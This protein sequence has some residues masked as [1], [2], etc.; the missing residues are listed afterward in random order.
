VLYELARWPL[1]KDA[2]LTLSRR[3]IR[4]RCRASSLLVDGVA[5]DPLL[6]QCDPDAEGASGQRAQV[7]VIGRRPITGR[8]LPLYRKLLASPHLRVREAAVELLAGHPEVEDTPGIMAAALGA[9]EVGMVATAAE[10]VTQH[11]ERVALDLPSRGA[12][13][14]G[15][16]EAGHLLP[17]VAKSL[18]EALARK[19]APD[20]VETLGSVV[21]AAGATHL[22]GIAS[23]LETFCKDANPTLREHAARAL[24]LIKEPRV[25]CPAPPEAK[26]GAPELLHLVSSP[27]KL[28]LITD[29]GTLTMMLD[30]THAPV[31]VTR[32]VDLARDGFY[33][34]IVV[35]RVVPGFVAQFGDPGADGF[36][37]PG[38]EPLR[39]E[40]TPVPYGAFDVGV[41]LAGRDTGS[42][43]L[44]VTAARYP[45]LDQEYALIGKADGD[46]NAVAEGDVIRSV[47]VLP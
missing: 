3:I 33:N 36:G 44:F 13:L 18:R 26:Q 39:C 8:R 38:R 12:H 2:P 22:D 14:E 34:G 23:Q 41:A 40:T 47:R 30:P 17:D 7:D 6:L 24:S 35:H 29:A 27:V 10:F 31:T 25:D 45:N 19:W 20:D 1:P 4:M 42:S 43:Q 5:D 46:W 11:P 37:G 9:K 15:G 28:E 21:E 16:L 32:V